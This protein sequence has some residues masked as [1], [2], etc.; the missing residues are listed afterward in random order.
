MKIRPLKKS[1]IRSTSKIV[2]ENYSRRYQLNAA[3]E[4]R[5]EWRNHVDP[6]RYIVAE[7]SGKI[8]GLG[9]YTQSWMDYHIYNVFWINVEPKWQGRGVGTKIMQKIISD[10]KKKRG[11]DKTASMILLTTDKPGFYSE[12][13][14]FKTLSMFRHNKHYLMGLKVDR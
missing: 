10:I 7:E 2:L 13:F 12:K 1:D 14:G 6:P 9:G 8:I 11:L 5:A 3:K 4:M